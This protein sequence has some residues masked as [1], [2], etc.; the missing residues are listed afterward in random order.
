MEARLKPGFVSGGGTGTRDIDMR[1][2]PYTDLQVGSYLL[3]AAEYRTIR[4]E[5]AGQLPFLQSLYILATVVST[6]SAS[7]ITVDAGTKA[8]AVSGPVRDH[9]IDVPAGSSYRF[10]GDE[11]GLITLP[12]SAAP[13]RAG[14][15]ILI[16][17][18]HCDPTRQFAPRLSYRDEWMTVSRLAD[19]RALCG[20]RFAAFTASPKVFDMKHIRYSKFERSYRK[21]ETRRAV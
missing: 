7:E 17:A 13:L 8:L 1:E 4:G 15:R 5:D 6:R 3:M 2:G 21:Q 14:A 12:K 16:P 10:W 9:F 11:H 18:T 20:A 19:P